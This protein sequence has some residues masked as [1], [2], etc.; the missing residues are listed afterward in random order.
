MATM[1]IDNMLQSNGFQSK[2]KE[3]ADNDNLWYA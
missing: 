2:K 1:A 3:D